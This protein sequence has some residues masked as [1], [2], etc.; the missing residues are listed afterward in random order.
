MLSVVIVYKR[1]NEAAKIT[2][3]HGRAHK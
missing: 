2:F 3:L 1:S